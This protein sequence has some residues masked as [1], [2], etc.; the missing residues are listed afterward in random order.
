MIFD[1]SVLLSKFSIQDLYS[2]MS[3]NTYI[4]TYICTKVHTI[5]FAFI[6]ICVS[7]CI[8]KHMH[9]RIFVHIHREILIYAWLCIYM[10]ACI[11]ME[12]S[13]RALFENGIS[14]NPKNEFAMPMLNSDIMVY[15]RVLPNICEELFSK[16]RSTNLA[17]QSHCKAFCSTLIA[18]W[19]RAPYM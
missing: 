9:T 18:S 10:Y 14:V 12:Y 7:T 17:L 4:Y 19:E 2:F 15:K 13:W 5:M 8:H 6:H 3:L 11:Y 16:I 1:V